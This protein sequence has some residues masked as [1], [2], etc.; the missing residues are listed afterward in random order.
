[1]KNLIKLRHLNF[2]IFLLENNFLGDKTGKGFYQK[3]K[4]KDENGR[5]IINAIDLKT[6]EYRKSVRPKISLIKRG[7]RY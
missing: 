6:L 7:K 1:M 3:T 2:L 5:T 4:Q